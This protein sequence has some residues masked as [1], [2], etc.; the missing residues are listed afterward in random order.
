MQAL[1][2]CVLD[3]DTGGEEINEADEAMA[4]I[5]RHK[6]APLTRRQID[7]FA[8]GITVKYGKL[9]GQC[10]LDELKVGDQP[11]YNGQTTQQ[12]GGKK[13]KKQYLAQPVGY[14]GVLVELQRARPDLQVRI[15][16]FLRSFA[17]L[18]TSSVHCDSR[19]LFRSS[20][21]APSA[22]GRAS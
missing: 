16:G 14:M 8:A 17:T 22:C 7:A 11:V 3:G 6:S 9:A 15:R 13:R 10:V 18:P 19:G 21:S 4:T 12:G 2:R 20:T 5:Y 1:M